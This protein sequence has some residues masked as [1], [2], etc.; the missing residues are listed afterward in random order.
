MHMPGL[1]PLLLTL[2]ILGPLLV[3]WFQIFSK[4]G[5]SGWL[6]LLLLVPLVNFILI[7][8]FGF[9]RWPILKRISTTANQT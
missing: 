2:L 4:A 8:W 7:L 1:I 5:Y 6:C 9:S 3:A